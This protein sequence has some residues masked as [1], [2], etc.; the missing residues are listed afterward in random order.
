[1]LASRPVNSP[2]Q[3]GLPFLRKVVPRPSPGRLLATVFAEAF[4]R[5]MRGQGLVRRL[6]ELDRKH[7]R[8]YVTELPWPLDLCVDGHRLRAADTGTTM[9]IAIR[10]SLDDLR[11][12]AMRTEDADTLFFERRLCFEGETH[13]GLL[14]KN[15]L[16]ALDWDWEA[17]LRSS[18]PPRL[19]SVAIAL[20]REIRQRRS[21][22]G[23][24]R[25]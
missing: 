12:L 23:T 9:N 4:N 13:T 2:A 24:P 6:P 8:L 22:P 5:T 3:A 15:M 17:H 14:I 1:M 10:G 7:I 20:G 18:L 16:D 11:C 19:A 21:M 25:R